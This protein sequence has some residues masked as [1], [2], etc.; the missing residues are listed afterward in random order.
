MFDLLSM[1][2]EEME[3]MMTDHGF[4]AYRGR[5]VFSWLFEKR[6]TSFAAMSNLPADLRAWLQKNA[7][8]PLPS[9]LA[10]QQ[11]TGGETV[12][13]LFRFADGVAVET[14]L[15]CYEKEG[16]KDRTTVCVSTQAGCAM[17]CAFCASTQEGL[18]R[19]LKA[20]EIISQVF[21]AQRFVSEHK[22]G[23][24]TNIV[25]MGMGEPLAN[26][27]AVWKSIRL[28]NEGLGIGMRRITVSTCGIVPKIRELAALA[29]QFTLAVSL[30]APED[31]L[32]SRLMPITRHYPIRELMAVIDEFIAKTNRRVTI[33]YALFR[34]VNDKTGHLL[35]ALLRGRLVHVNVLLANPVAE[36]KFRPAAEDRV[37]AFTAALAEAG[38]PF[39]VR[40]SMGSEIDAACGQLRRRYGPAASKM[41]PKKRDI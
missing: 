18:E 38:I 11:G 9:I 40:K 4:P 28:C 26:W 23:P 14:V 22:K 33:E 24:V 15:M 25:Y 36:S 3:A 16:V 37:R 29:P 17:G 39:T 7:I 27:P 41:P 32:R 21:L 19:N 6:V 5:Q 13:F 8:V 12:K 20:G 1:T 2:K 30:H 34:G 35:A 10:C 31:E